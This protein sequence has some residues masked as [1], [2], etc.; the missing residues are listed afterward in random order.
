MA[1]SAPDFE[2]HW[3]LWRSYLAVMRAGSLSAAARR[4]GLSQPTV[5]R[6]IE[7]LE[8]ALAATL[9]ER[10]GR[11]LRPTAT[12]QRLFEPVAAAEAALGSARLAAAG[13][14]E[15]LAG[16]VRITA[17]NMVSHAVLPARLAAIRQAYPQIQLEL[18]SS[19]TPDNL[20]LRE[21]DIAIRMFR[22]GQLDVVTRKLGEIALV[23]C[24]H[25]DYLE[26]R[27]TPRTVEDLAA[28]DLIGLDRSEEIIRV[29]RSLG[30]SLSR[31]DFALRT[32]SH[33][34][35][36]ELAKAGLGI[37]FGQLPLVEET[38]AMVAILPDLAIPPMEV[39]LTTH[40]ELWTS[41]RI[42]VVYELLA[43][44]MTAYIERRVPSLAPPSPVP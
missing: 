38:E 37:A 27:G 19:D 9:F 10:T 1:L 39:W 3:S 11:G 25:A 42:R 41:R 7:E 29:A 13:A 23:A 21:A 4:L 32:D 22:P 2:P 15:E 40:R 34:Q 5:G 35:G 12:G 44:I 31:A 36:W 33:P 20:L 8:G 18:V 43:E 6:H 17:S 14:A 30:F 28:H 26:R 16:T 24:A